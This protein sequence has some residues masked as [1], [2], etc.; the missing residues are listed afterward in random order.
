MR[1]S[2]KLKVSAVAGTESS[3]G[4]EEIDILL[5]EKGKFLVCSA[6]SI[7]CAY[8]ILMP[9]FTESGIEWAWAEP[10]KSC[11]TL[12]AVLLLNFASL[13]CLILV[14]PDA[15]RTTRRFVLVG[16]MFLSVFLLGVVF[17]TLAPGTKL[18]LLLFIPVG[19]ATLVFAIVYDRRFA[20]VCAGY[21][22]LTAAVALH[23]RG[24]DSAAPGALSGIPLLAVHLMSSV[25][26]ALSVAEIR[27]RSKLV[28]VGALLGISHGAFAVIFMSA[29][30]GGRVL[31][32]LDMLALNGVSGVCY[33]L[34]VGFLLTGALPFIEYLFGVSTDI[35]LLEL[36]DQ[37]HPILRRLLLEA[38]GTFHHSFIV[39]TLAEAAAGAVGANAL[40]ARVGGYYHDIGKLMKPE[41]FTENES[42][43]GSHHANL[44]P[45]MSTLIIVAHIKDGVEIGRDYNLPPAIMEFIPQHHGTSVVEYF[46]HEAMQRS[47]EQSVSRDFFR[48]QGPKPQTKETA[49]V[50][51]AD[52]VEAA[53]RSLSDPTPARIKGM[54]HQIV[55]YKLMDDQLAES[56]LDFHELT[57]IEEEFVRVL[58]GIF[59]GRIAY[60]EP[61]RK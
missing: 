34:V 32:E 19:F 9:H 35:S 23:L 24:G 45:T 14:F 13:A 4:P 58:S 15:V 28:K 6:Y 12:A 50:F 26:A 46:Y 42:H 47:P 22:T 25:V 8:V 11:S 18:D 60:P 49:V 55:N 31:E 40:L 21:M 59:H 56:R 16:A 27:R 39:G 2:R 37:N 1:R 61:V 30:M 17:A 48:Y 33:G 53:S 57:M 7:F 51:L 3:K 41:Y 36:T 38:P 54:V 44:S 52:S 5:R 29:G 20:V 10:W 43:K